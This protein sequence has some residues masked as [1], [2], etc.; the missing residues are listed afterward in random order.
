LVEDHKY[1]YVSV[2]RY[3]KILVSGKHSVASNQNFVL[4]ENLYLTLPDLD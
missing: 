1:K 2:G 4:D 3:K